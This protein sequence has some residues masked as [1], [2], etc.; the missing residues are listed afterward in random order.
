MDKIQVKINGCKL[1][2]DLPKLTQQS[3]YYGNSKIIVIGESPAKNGWLASGNA[4][5]DI[6]G[7]LLAS[8]RVLEKLLSI[9][10]LSL[11]DINFTECCKCLMPDRKQLEKC[12]QNCLPFLIQQLNNIECD[13][14]LTMGMYPTQTIL[15]TK[16]KKYSDYVGK[17]QNIK[18][19]NKSY[20][21][22]PIYHPSPANPKGYK[23]NIA[24][25]E[26]LKT[27]I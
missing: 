21:L 17:M 8:G 12:S 22:L 24:I 2:G 7:K 19:G 20:I 1:C 13:I 16:I 6:N 18:L 15:N 23:N 5:Y 3:I 4:F 14:I 11:T 27:I 26:Y 10:N 25:F 9:V